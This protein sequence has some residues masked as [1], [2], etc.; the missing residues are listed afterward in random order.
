MMNPLLRL[1]ELDDIFFV[2]TVV[3]GADLLLE[4]GAAR[5]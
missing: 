3:S 5:E 4:G 1:T 2:I